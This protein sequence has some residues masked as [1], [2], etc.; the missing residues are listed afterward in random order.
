MNPRWYPI[1]IT[2]PLAKSK[3]TERQ[4]VHNDRYA[5]PWLTPNKVFRTGGETNIVLSN[6]IQ[7]SH[8]EQDEDTSDLKR[9]ENKYQEMTQNYTTNILKSM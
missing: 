5:A 8:A 1:R 4:C 6:L 3:A 2:V 7:E 9:M